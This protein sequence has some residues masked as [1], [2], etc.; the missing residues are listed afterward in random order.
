MELVITP[1]MEA[2]LEAAGWAR[3]QRLG[4][5]SAVLDIEGQRFILQEHLTD[6]GSLQAWLVLQL[7]A[8]QMIADARRE[9]NL[10]RIAAVV[11]VA[12][13]RLVSM[14]LGISEDEAAALPGSVRREV[15]R[16]Q[17]QLNATA[18]YVAVLN[19]GGRAAQ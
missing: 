9:G 3:V 18:L 7:E 4:R 15:I 11:Q 1:E 13:L 8:G 6:D 19:G 10:H 14:A 2:A 17:D 16:R 12:N 5:R